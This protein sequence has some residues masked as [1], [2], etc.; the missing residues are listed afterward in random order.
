[1]NLMGKSGVWAVRWVIHVPSLWYELIINYMPRYRNEP[2]GSIISWNIVC[3]FFFTKRSCVSII[4]LSC[5]FITFAYLLYKCIYYICYIF[6]WGCTVSVH[7]RT[8]KLS[9]AFVVCARIAT[10]CL[11]RGLFNGRDDARN[12]FVKTSYF[13]LSSHSH[14]EFT[15]AR[16]T[17]T[18]T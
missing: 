2:A 14:G 7:P 9:A 18:T 10:Y 1:M 3:F 12:D 4:I 6:A 5:T 17:L 13:L 16:V 8:Q 11:R 15:L